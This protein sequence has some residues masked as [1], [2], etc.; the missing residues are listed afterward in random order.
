MMANELITEIEECGGFVAL[1]LNGERLRVRLPSE[2]APDFVARLKAIKSDV[3]AVLRRRTITYLDAPC[4]C[5]EKPFPH[6]Q[7]HDGTG[8]G[9]GVRR[10]RVDLDALWS[11]PCPCGSREWWKLGGQVLRCKGCGHRFRSDY[12]AP[13][14]GRK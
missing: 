4:T 3:M 9:S 14:R 5:S 12:L 1:A 7:H 8:P 11:D 13:E 10:R 2:T 6:F